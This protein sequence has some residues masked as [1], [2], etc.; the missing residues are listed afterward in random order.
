MIIFLFIFYIYAVI[1]GMIKGPP[2]TQ[3]LGAVHQISIPIDSRRCELQN[4]TDRL[5][6]SGLIWSDAEE[7]V[8]RHEYITNSN[9]SQA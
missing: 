3:Q 7:A 5:H 4:E 6:A 9:Y 8:D 2:E 1:A